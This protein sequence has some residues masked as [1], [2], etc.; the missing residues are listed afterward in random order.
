MSESDQLGGGDPTVYWGIQ[1]DQD[2]IETLTAIY[3]E[4]FKEYNNNLKSNGKASVNLS[5]IAMADGSGIPSSF[6]PSKSP[7]K[8]D[9]DETP[10]QKTMDKH[11][12]SL[13][14]KLLLR[15]PIN[16]LVDQGIMPPLKTPPSFHEQ[17][18]K[19][20]RAK[21]GDI[22]KSK[23]QRR[24]DRQ[25][26]IQQHILED[27]NVDPSLQDKQRQLKKARLA[28]DLNER[29][30]HRPGPLELIKGN[31][32]KADEIFAQAIKDGQIPFKRTCEG[33]SRKHAPPPFVFEED[34]SS[35]GAMSPLQEM[36]QTQTASTNNSHSPPDINIPVSSPSLGSAVSS[37]SPLS[38]VASPAS[39]SMSPANLSAFISTTAA[40]SS[41]LSIST[42]LIS[43]A[44]KVP[45]TTSCSSTSS[46]GSCTTRSDLVGKETNR[47]RKKSKSKSAPKT[48]T[49]KF[50][51]YKG[52]PN[53][54]KNYQPNSPDGETS[55][56]LLLQ[57]Q[58]LFLQWQLELQH[59]YP[60][61]ILPAAQ[62]TS[63]DTVA[64]V[65][66]T[67]GL[68]GV[69]GMVPSPGLSQE[70]HLPTRCLTKLEDMKVCD[71]KMELKKRNLTV[72]G[73]K[74]QLIE[75]LRPYSDQ[76]TV[77]ISANNPTPST[78]SGIINGE[79]S[80]CPSSLN[81]DSSSQGSP[82]E[83]SN[84]PKHIEDH[85]SGSPSSDHMIDHDSLEAS[86]TETVSGD[87]IYTVTT[88]SPY[89]MSM[90]GTPLH[91]P[92][93]V[94]PMEI[95]GNANTEYD[96]L[97]L[98]EVGRSLP[99]M[100]STPS[101]QLPPPPPPLPLTTSSLPITLTF[102]QNF[103][104]IYNEDALRKK[105]EEL[106]RELQRSQ[107]QLQQQQQHQSMIHR[108][109]TL[110]QSSQQAPSP[111]PNSQTQTVT[112]VVPN[113]SVS[114][115]KSPSNNNNAPQMGSQQKLQQQKLLLQQHIQ[116]KLHNQQQL[117]Q[118]A[119]NSNPAPGSV[120][121]KASLAAFLQ[122]QTSAAT[123]VVNP[124]I[125]PKLYVCVESNTSIS[126]TT[127]E[128]CDNNSTDSTGV[129]DAL[130]NSNK[131]R[132]NSLPNGLGHTRTNSLPN[133]VG[134]TT[135]PQK[136]PIVRTTT[137]PQFMFNKPPPDY[138]E[139]TKQ[140]KQQFTQTLIETLN[141][142][143]RGRKSVKSQDV[144]DVLEILIKNGELPPSAAQEP[145]TPP[146]PKGLQTPHLFA[147][148]NASN[149]ITSSN[150]LQVP[151]T[152]VNERR[153]NNTEASVMMPRQQTHL[154]VDN[155]M[156]TGISSTT[157]PNPSTPPTF[158][159]DLNLDLDTLEPMNLE[160]FAMDTHMKADPSD[161]L[162]VSSVG[163]QADS[164]AN[165]VTHDFNMFVDDAMHID[166]DMT[167]VSDWLDEILP[168]TV[169]SNAN[170]N[171]NN[172]SA[173]DSL[174][175]HLNVLLPST[176]SSIAHHVDCNDPLLSANQDIFNLLNLEDDF[177]TSDLG[178]LAW[179][180]VDFAT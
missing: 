180:K 66:L 71:L 25:E 157:S 22:L 176:N 169:I 85:H 58:Q 69:Q 108:Q 124:N 161:Y 137:D 174:A 60:Q 48:R 123:T 104:Q 44:S 103:N 40:P 70:T 88:A 13:K 8:T 56:E 91:R 144:E 102:E 122:G 76:A 21:M 151:P 167:D 133:F 62:K 109:Q 52:P 19:F 73:S 55:Y 118:L 59:K 142:P 134:L 74:P 153:Q 90:A 130:I 79:S 119:A 57:Q 34:S 110:Q 154:S 75:R 96:R 45:S 87:M 42:S 115:V 168:N 29:L 23:I 38:S 172:N 113:I 39:V 116:Q 92:P 159:L 112:N 24:P 163:S 2:L 15:R 31:I 164:S 50:H 138:D 3:P 28:D 179:D 100:S 32:L 10:I 155:V 135:I 46:S 93:S 95:E 162:G 11:K 145:P 177:K 54:Q 49:I 129:N 35:E 165:S 12:E 127:S 152:S 166:I 27:S 121:V 20:E 41:L 107:M 63:S 64:V 1:L 136:Q 67:S 170:M 143:V 30:S 105:I 7:S 77:V 132:A 80:S 47:S 98:S 16:Q 53:A 178:V 5:P 89:S 146:T 131:Q 141:R 26:L 18:Q 106:Q 117:Q 171:I 147:A 114:E 86:I 150:T 33:E 83:D 61:I 68:S 125:Q 14:V 9:V 175:S 111:S 82:A 37:L 97:E 148:T 156:D 173:N 94:A 78:S 43:P 51:E 99:Q 101:S 84:M 6:G 120:N 126:E 4:W 36:D 140:L 81:L 17:R 128:I 160:G 158:D 65:N 139:A 149:G 72:S